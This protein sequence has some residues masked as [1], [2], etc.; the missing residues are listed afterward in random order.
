MDFM[1]ELF[2]LFKFSTKNKAL[3]NAEESE[4]STNITNIVKTISQKLIEI[5]SKLE[6][7]YHKNSLILIR[8]NSTFEIDNL[9]SSM[10]NFTPTSSDLFFI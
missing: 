8:T 9:N 7:I 4:N 1:V 3:N 10:S 2:K 5:E 6:M